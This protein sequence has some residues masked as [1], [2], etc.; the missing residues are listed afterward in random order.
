MTPVAA[1]FP[2]P[3]DLA[4]ARFSNTF[5]AELPADPVTVNVPR[6]VSGAG[7]TLVQPTPVAA[8]RLLAWSGD[9]ANTLGLA[10]PSP[11]SI[12]ILSGNRVSPG[13][14]PYAARYGGHQ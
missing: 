13:M 7:Y 8:P 6:Q 9:L 3:V 1:T 11:A 5:V 4:N 2:Q 12:E 14:K 10:F